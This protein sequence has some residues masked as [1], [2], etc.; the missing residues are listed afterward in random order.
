M[1]PE[2]YKFA[3][4]LSGENPELSA[5][6][7]HFAS[8]IEIER[9]EPGDDGRANGMAGRLVLSNEQAKI[10]ILSRLAYTLKAYEIIDQHDTPLKAI[11]LTKKISSAVWIEKLDL[12]NP[13]KNA[14]STSELLNLIN[15]KKSRAGKPLAVIFAN[16]KCYFAIPYFEN[17]HKFSQRHPSQRP[18]FAPVS[19][20]AKLLRSMVNMTGAR[21]GSKIIDPFC[22]SGGILIE[23]GLAGFIAEGSDIDERMIKKSEQNLE[24]FGI[25]RYS[26]KLSDA[27]SLEYDNKYVV[28]ELPFGRG[29]KLS[30]PPEELYSKFFSKLKISK[31]KRAVVMAPKDINAGK[32]AAG[33]GLIILGNYSMYVHK[34]LTK[35]IIILEHP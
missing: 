23:A 33:Y 17:T 11:D 31:F 27:L 1:K 21:A 2:L 16:N 3:Y 10:G 15:V 28:T 13:Q 18:G 24:H 35:Q 30:L 20:S 25:K 6:E 19:S 29:A 12:Q 34:S 9:I 22:G 5:A 8:E 7:L 26:L 4:Y 32:I 14:I